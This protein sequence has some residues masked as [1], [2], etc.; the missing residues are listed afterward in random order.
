M[1]DHQKMGC[2]FMW[3]NIVGSVEALKSGSDGS[4]CVL[5]HCMGL[6]ECRCS[7]CMWMCINDDVNS[8]DDD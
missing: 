7:V 2:S 3:S 6:G 5:A 8:F 1:H 4:G